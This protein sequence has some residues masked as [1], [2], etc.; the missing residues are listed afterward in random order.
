MLKS[1]L[2]FA[3]WEKSSPERRIHSGAR[4]D[5]QNPEGLSHA[6]ARV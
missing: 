5:E 3:A 6:G 2:L 1:P 4:R